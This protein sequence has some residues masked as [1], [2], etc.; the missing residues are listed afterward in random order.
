MFFY[1][2][3]C[4]FFQVHFFTYRW[5]HFQY[6]EMCKLRTKTSSALMVCYCYCFAVTPDVT[7][8]NFWFRFRCDLLILNAPH[9]GLWSTRLLRYWLSIEVN[10]NSC[11]AITYWFIDQ[12]H[13]CLSVR[14]K[15]I[16]VF[17]HEW[18]KSIGLKQR[19]VSKFE[20]R[21]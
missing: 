17:R 8:Y 12:L 11:D 4:V 6:I 1:V 9:F 15:W 3:L 5:N 18:C 14:R 2:F 20:G 10:M 16:L 19:F 21:V 13:K 7:N